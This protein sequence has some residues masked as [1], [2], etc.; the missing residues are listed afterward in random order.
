MVGHHRH[1][2]FLLVHSP[3]LGP[4]TWQWVSDALVSRGHTTALPDLR[5]AALTGDPTAFASTAVAAE[6]SGDDIIV[7]G[8]SG[9]GS[10]LPIIAAAMPS[11]VRTVF[12]DA[13]MPPCDGAFSA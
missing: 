3:V 1:V 9:A 10:V 4:V 12:V 8:H 6:V 5:S 11:V 2:R 13:G 7:A